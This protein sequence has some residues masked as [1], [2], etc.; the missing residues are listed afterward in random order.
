ML[1]NIVD[2]FKRGLNRKN[3]LVRYFRKMEQTANRN[4][5]VMLSRMRSLLLTNRDKE[6]KALKLEA[7]LSKMYVGVY[8]RP[9]EQMKNDWNDGQEKKMALTKRFVSKL[10]SR[11]SH[12][13]ELLQ[14]HSNEQRSN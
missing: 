4:V 12:S 2:S 3:S 11:I 9:L 10:G 6:V 1:K 5:S 13:L 7:T 14:K 8:K